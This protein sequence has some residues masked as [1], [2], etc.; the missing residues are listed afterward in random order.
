MSILMWLLLF[1]V[2]IA[3]AIGAITF[4]EK[5]LAL[6]AFIKRG[7]KWIWDKINTPKSEN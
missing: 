1:A 2:I 6:V 3:F 7:L 5:G 4:T